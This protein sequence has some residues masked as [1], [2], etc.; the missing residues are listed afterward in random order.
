ME[1]VAHAD[2]I[3]E[4]TSF[5]KA[6]EKVDITASTILTTSHGSEQGHRPAPVAS[7]GDHDLVAMSFHQVAQL[8]HDST[9]PEPHDNGK[10]VGRAALQ[11]ERSAQLMTATR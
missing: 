11:R 6:D 2:E 4:G 5:F 8:T 1:V 10:A 7:D 9:K 3:E